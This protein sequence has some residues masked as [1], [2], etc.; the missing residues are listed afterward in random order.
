[1]NHDT[2]TLTYDHLINQKEE[3]NKRTKEMENRIN[4]HIWFKPF[5]QILDQDHF[6]LH[7]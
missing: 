7:H 1:V 3:K 6:G 2:K 4:T 5:L